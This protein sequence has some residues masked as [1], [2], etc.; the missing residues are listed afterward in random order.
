MDGFELTQ[1]LRADPR[2]ARLPIIAFTSTVNDIFKQRALK[3]GI[4][5][6]ILKTDREALLAEMTQQLS[7]K[8]EV[9]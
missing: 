5:G 6:I 4:D 8:R 7:I 9:A 1:R 2:M 3:V